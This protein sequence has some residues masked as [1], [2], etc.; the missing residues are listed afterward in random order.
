MILQLLHKLL[1]LLLELV[2]LL[3]S[4]YLLLPNSCCQV[5][6]SKSDFLLILRLPELLVLLMPLLL[7]FR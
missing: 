1:L 7:P 2:Q 5:L 4:N 6:L 3:V